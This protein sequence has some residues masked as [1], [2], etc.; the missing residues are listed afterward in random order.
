MRKLNT[1]GLREEQIEAFA[2][3]SDPAIG[4]NRKKEK[5]TN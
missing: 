2:S 5:Q 1:G 4:S 3:G